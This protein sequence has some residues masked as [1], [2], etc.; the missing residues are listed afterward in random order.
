MAARKAHPVNRLERW[1]LG[2]ILYATTCTSC[3]PPGLVPMVWR[4]DTRMVVGVR[5]DSVAAAGSIAVFRAASPNEA[6]VCY[7]G[8]L[9]DSTDSPLKIL[10]LTGVSPAASDS[11]DPRDVWF[12]STNAGCGPQTVAI[13]HSHPPDARCDHSDR[14]AYTLF[15][16]PSALVS[17]VWCPSGELSYL[18]Q[19]GTRT[20]GRWRTEP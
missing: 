10:E 17:V 14:D 20:A 1:A 7:R 2:A 19:D 18:W 13:G 8:V 9:R 6:A 15:G 4:P 3:A 12:G 5:M 11:A 16:Y